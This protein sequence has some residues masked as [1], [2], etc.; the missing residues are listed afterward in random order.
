MN[1]SEVFQ[2]NKKYKNQ[3][4]VILGALLVSIFLSLVLSLSVFK[5]IG[6]ERIVISPISINRDFWLDSD[7]ISD[8]YMEQITDFFVNLILNVSPSNYQYRIDQ[9]LRHVHPDTYP[10]L[11]KS[12]ANQGELVNKKAMSTSF[13]VTKQKIERE[14]FTNFVTGELKIM[15]GNQVVE[16]LT[17]TYKVS[18]FYQ[19][20]RLLLKEFSD[21]SQDQ[22]N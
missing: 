17:K 21:V 11:K 19:N 7:A 5:I 15:V 6:T 1:V 14:K 13:F 2:E 20:G 9:V 10:V 22:S 8:S 4:N 12:F 16:Q 18:Y 3:R